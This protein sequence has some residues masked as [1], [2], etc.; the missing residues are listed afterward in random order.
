MNQFALFHFTIEKNN[1]LYQFVVQPGSSWEDIESALDEF[2]TN[3]QDLKAEAQKQEQ[4]TGEVV[5]DK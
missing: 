4:A 1:K 5:A 2:K 3:M